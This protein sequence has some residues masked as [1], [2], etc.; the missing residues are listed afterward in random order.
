VRQNPNILIG[1]ILV[2]SNQGNEA[3]TWQENRL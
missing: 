3:A 1:K 2:P